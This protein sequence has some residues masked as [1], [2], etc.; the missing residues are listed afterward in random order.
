MSTKPTVI[1]VKKRLAELRKLP[2]AARSPAQREEMLGLEKAVLAQKQAALAQ[3]AHALRSADAKARTHK[4]IGLGGLVAKA[5]LDHL[6][7]ATLLGALLDV[8]ALAG[9]EPTMLATWKAAGGKAMNVASTDVRRPL[10]VKF[11]K[12]ADTEV[13]KGL[14]ALKL[15]WSEVRQEWDGFADPVAVEALVRPAGGIV[16]EAGRS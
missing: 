15:R 6:D 12:P 5:G 11:S 14:R 4:L 8:A 7:S 2:A 3:R 16:R 10:I 9:R 13:R 1:D